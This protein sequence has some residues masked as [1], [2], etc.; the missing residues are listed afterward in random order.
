L[1]PDFYFG[2]TGLSGCFSEGFSLW[3]SHAAQKLVSEG[4]SIDDNAGV[5]REDL[6]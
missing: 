1:L 5:L 6:T 3:R 2:A 4:T